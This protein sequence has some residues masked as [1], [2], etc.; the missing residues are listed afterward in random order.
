MEH[1]KIVRDYCGISISTVEFVLKN[2]NFA[3]ILNYPIKIYKRK[4]SVIEAE[5]LFRNIED[6]VPVNWLL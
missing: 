5:E 4:L 3:E 6:F 2:T 1:K